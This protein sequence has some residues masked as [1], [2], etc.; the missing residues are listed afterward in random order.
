[1]IDD[2]KSSGLSG[3]MGIFRARHCGMLVC[4]R[5]C[6]CVCVCVRVCVCVC[7]FVCWCGCDRVFVLTLLAFGGMSRAR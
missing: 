1:M 4:R 7:V 6:V 2:E 5:V 3:L